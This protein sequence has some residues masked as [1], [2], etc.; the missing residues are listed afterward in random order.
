MFKLLGK[1]L[2]NFFDDR[3][4][5]LIFIVFM[6]GLFLYI[7]APTVSTLLSPFGFQSKAELKQVVQD[8]QKAIETITQ[9]NELLEHHVEMT[10][11]I[12]TAIINQAVEVQKQQATKH[13]Q[14][15]KINTVKHKAIERIHKHYASPTKTHKQSQ[16]IKR[17]IHKKISNVQITAIWDTYCLYNSH[18]TCH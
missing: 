18:A 2:S 6:V 5:A 10:E 16:A 3:N 4:I 15:T 11:K 7:I 14:L 12:T 13:K 17:V 9:S 1:A 8:Q